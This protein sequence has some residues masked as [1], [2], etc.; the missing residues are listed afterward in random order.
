M[1]DTIGNLLAAWIF[2]CLSAFVAVAAYYRGKNLGFDHAN[3]L[4]DKHNR[5]LREQPEKFHQC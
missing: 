3:K 1:S 5:R 2:L 4:N